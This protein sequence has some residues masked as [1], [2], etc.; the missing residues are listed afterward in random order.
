MEMLMVKRRMQ[1]GLEGQE[2]ML[3]GSEGQTEMLIGVMINQPK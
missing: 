3:I 1:I 2:E